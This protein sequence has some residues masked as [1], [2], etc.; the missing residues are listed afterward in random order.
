MRF[1]GRAG[2][3]SF[4]ISSYSS[5][6][7][8]AACILMMF[9]ALESTLSRSRLLPIIVDPLWIWLGDYA[10]S[11]FDNLLGGS[12]EWAESITDT[13]VP[14]FFFETLLRL[15]FLLWP[16]L[17]LAG[18]EGRLLSSPSATVEWNF[19]NEAFAVRVF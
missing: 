1:Y 4:N 13:V 10:S 6:S 14:D 8:N 3:L 2:L 12:F 9:A 5:I 17:A 18:L 16:L 19:T 7:F 11:I 15:D